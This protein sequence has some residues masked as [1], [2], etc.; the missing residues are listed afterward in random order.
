MIQIIPGDRAGADNL[1]EIVDPICNAVMAARP[2]AQ[3]DRNSIAPED[4]MRVYVRR[5]CIAH[6]IAGIVHSG[7]C[8]GEGPQ[9]DCGRMVGALGVRDAVKRPED[10][11]LT[12]NGNYY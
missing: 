11:A 1:A 7:R 4:R 10:I 8:G 3:V 5:A 6:N 2:D 12:R 9:I